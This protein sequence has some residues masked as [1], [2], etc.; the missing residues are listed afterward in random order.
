M[1]ENKHEYANQ[2]NDTGLND[3]IYPYRK[4]LKV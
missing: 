3:G 1:L 4:I 2:I